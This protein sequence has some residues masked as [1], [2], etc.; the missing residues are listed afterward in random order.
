MLVF[1]LVEAVATCAHVCMCMCMCTICICMCICMCI[2]KCMCLCMCLWAYFVHFWVYVRVCANNL[3]VCICYSSIRL[4]WARDCVGREHV[5]THGGLPTQKHAWKI[6]C[7][8]IHKHV[9]MYLY[10]NTC[11]YIP[12]SGTKLPR[13]HRPWVSLVRFD[14]QMSSQMSQLFRQNLL[15]AS[16]LWT[17]SQASHCCLNACMHLYMR[18]C[19]CVVCVYAFLC[20]CVCMWNVVTSVY[21][22]MKGICSSFVYAH[23]S[24][25]SYGLG[26]LYT[27]LQKLTM[28]RQRASIP[29]HMHNNSFLIVTKCALYT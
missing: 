11:T 6:S 5:I 25:F 1:K 15:K 18:E 13:W 4:V 16:L 21:V 17:L 10:T 29:P 26:H 2:C 7:T 12:L 19:T 3:C 14:R 27:S 22:N 24:L 20:I 9:H 28:Q 8:N 23:L